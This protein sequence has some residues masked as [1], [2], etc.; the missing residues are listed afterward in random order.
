MRFLVGC[1]EVFLVAIVIS[2]T[3]PGQ[4]TAQ[5]PNP[6]FEV[7]NAGLPEGWITSNVPGIATPLTASTTR[8]SGSFAA[9]GEVVSAFSSAWP[10][11]LWSVFPQ[12]QLPQSIQFYYQFAPLG[13]DELLVTVFFYDGFQPI[14][15]ADTAI[16]AAAGAFTLLDLPVEA[17]LP[18]TP[19]S[20]YIYISIA[21]TGQEGNPTLGS[22]FHID[23]V[24]FFGVTSV[25]NASDVPA[26]FEL[27]QNYPNPFNPST[28]I[29]YSVPE[30]GDVRLEVFN[31][32]GERVALLVDRRV[33]AGS[34]RAEFT[35]T[36]LPSGVYLYRLSAGASNVMVR[37][38]VLVK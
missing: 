29:E 15:A 1:I 24:G 5:I 36:A 12:T 38:M 11:N 31:L 18:G 2:L 27:G 34:H 30:A 10:P 4:M 7:W 23:D 17:F 8:R 16:T 28:T 25:E 20:C 6:G 14:A 26:V 22:T 35:A 37:R 3:V 13:G 21:G 32:V 33:A 19:D 9:R